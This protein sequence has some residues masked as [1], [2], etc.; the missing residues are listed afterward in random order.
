MKNGHGQS[1]RRVLPAKP[2]NK[3]GGARQRGHGR[4]YSGTKVETPETAK[5]TPTE[6]VPEI[7]TSTEEVEGRRLAKGNLGQQN[8][9]RTQG[10]SRMHS[11]LERVRTA[12]QA[13]R[14]TR[15]TALLHHVYNMDTLREAYFRLY[16]KA[17]PGIDG[18][19][20]QQYGKN[21][22]ENLKDLSARLK[23]RAY[24]AKSVRRV[25]IP[26]ADG[27]RRPIGVTTLEDKIV[28]Q[29]A[30]MVL[31]A[32]YEED[33]LGFSY[34][35]RPRRNP[36]NA[37]DA[38]TVGI[39]R[40]KVNW[41]LDADIRG[42]FDA[43]SHEWTLR[44][45]EHRIADQRIVR[46]IQ[47]W[48]NA[49]ILEEGKRIQVEEGTPQGGSISPLLANIYLHYVF[50]LW[51]QV[52]RRKR[53]QGDVIIVRYADDI[54]LGFQHRDDAQRFLTE[55]CQR[56]AKFGLELHPDKTRII[57]FGRF[58]HS[59]RTEREKG[60]PETFDFLGFT[61]YCGK[62]RNGKFTVRRR[63]V[64]KRLRQKL[65]QVKSELMHRRHDP[66]PEVGE[67]LR[68]VLM[69]HFHYYGVPHN[70]P[71]LDAF[72]SEVARHWRK[73]LSCRSQKGYVTWERMSRLKRRW[74]PSARIHHPYPNERLCVIT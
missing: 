21:L 57:E 33:F 30:V 40:K 34:G 52:W 4:P 25:Y 38:L 73:A 3:D 49:G 47:K 10:R 26:K 17:A 65:R 31:N 43:I 41:V 35:F 60:K 56:F 55:L 48:L 44:F 29:A 12:A 74:F 5:G 61:H 6:P 66:V 2:P 14:E 63:T 22:E 16:R 7:R 13:D 23:S 58:A 9:L 27:G 37:L 69:G 28:Q 32:V 67:W 50:D 36:H 68:S 51:A 59:N 42:F 1:D 20:W 45:V 39:E 72:R 11:A 64:K 24:R 53:A 19:T 8:M 54:A 18:V 70:G 46:L 71:A 15:F 62:T